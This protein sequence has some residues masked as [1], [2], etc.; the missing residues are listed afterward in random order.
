MDIGF[1]QSLPNLA[2]VDCLLYGKI[3]G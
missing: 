2:R 3:K 1:G